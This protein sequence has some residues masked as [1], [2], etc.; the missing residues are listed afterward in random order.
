MNKYTWLVVWNIWII[1]PYI[2][3]VIIPT[4]EF[5]FFRGVGLN[6]Q[7]DKLVIMEVTIRPFAHE[8]LKWIH[9]WSAA[10]ENLQDLEA[11]FHSFL[12]TFD[13]L[14]L[15]SVHQILR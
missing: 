1:F 5:I 9:L 15:K 8:D 14:L 4:D 13:L 12:V 6:H 10:I 7:P 3:N 11:I 2:G